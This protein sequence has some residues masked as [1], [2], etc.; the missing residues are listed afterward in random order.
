MLLAAA[1]AYV[2]RVE[3]AVRELQLALIMRPGDGVLL[4]NAACVLC[5]LGRKAE[6]IQALKDAL[7]AGFHPHPGWARRDR[8]L[9]LLHGDPQFDEMF[10]PEVTD[11]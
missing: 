1:Y 8:D 5:L 2:G 11:R 7:N 3:E 6:A 10:P 4:Y 9:A